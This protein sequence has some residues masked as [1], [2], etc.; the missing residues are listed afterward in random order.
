MRRP[1]RFTDRQLLWLA[2]AHS[3][4][5]SRWRPQE[6][7]SLV[8]DVR[9]MIHCESHGIEVYRFANMVRESGL[10]HFISTRRGGVS[11]A[12]YQALNLAFHVG[13]SAENVRTNRQRLLGS[14]GI[15]VESI[16]AGDQV[17]SSNVSI[18]S[19]AV[20]GSGAFAQDTAVPNTDAL[21]TE[22]PYTCL[23]VMLADCVPVMLYD[24][25]RNVIAVVHAGWRG[26]V[27]GI[28]TNTV[29]TMMEALGS[30]P[31]DILAGI[32]P[33]ISPGRYEVGPDVLEKARCVFPGL[34]VIKD[35]GDGKGYFDLWTA[36]FHQLQAMSIPQKNIEV[37]RI[38]SYTHWETFYSHRRQQPTG[39]FAAGAM[40]VG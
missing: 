35:T 3:E 10:L 4:R 24:R 17:H 32:G 23:V 2:A 25:R 22:E 8:R 7:L 16:I 14:M 15:P 28:V 18:V 13:D 20:R 38:C 27:A 33:S 36:N 9:K 19:A 31:A 40:L 6:I 30:R 12:P 5:K 37:S 21:I 29:H 11:G 26:T 39:R 34:D 1:H